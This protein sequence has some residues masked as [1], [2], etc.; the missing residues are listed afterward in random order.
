LDQKLSEISVPH[1]QRLYV[2]RALLRDAQILI[3]DEPTAKLNKDQANHLAITVKALG[4]RR[5]VI[6]IIHPDQF[7]FDQGAVKFLTIMPFFIE[8]A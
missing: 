2:C 7:R 3:P 4:R 6:V 8:G 1:L 5:T